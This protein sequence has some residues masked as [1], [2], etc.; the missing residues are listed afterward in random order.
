MLGITIAVI[1]QITFIKNFTVLK[2]TPMIKNYYFLAEGFITLIIIARDN[3]IAI[4]NSNLM[5]IMINIITIFIDFKEI[6]NVIVIN[7]SL[8][9]ITDAIN[10]FIKNL[11]Y[12]NFINSVDSS[13]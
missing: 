8:L 13:N 4:I 3:F 5:L 10:N 11:I 2:V 6:I 9:A 12:F 1:K 7:F